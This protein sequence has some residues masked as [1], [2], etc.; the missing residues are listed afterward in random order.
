MKNIQIWE[1]AKIAMNVTLPQAFCH[2][3]TFDL[4]RLS[5]LLSEEGFG[6][7]SG[8]DFYVITENGFWLLV[9]M[10]KRSAL[11]V[12]SFL[13]SFLNPFPYIWCNISEGV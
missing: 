1:T 10:M 3:N 12:V 13:D 9:V 2:F 7:A 6:T 8:V 4:S 11:V 5:F